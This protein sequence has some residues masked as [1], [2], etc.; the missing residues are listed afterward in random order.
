M[1]KT[2]LFPG[3]FDPFTRGHQYIVEQSLVLFDQIVIGVGVNGRKSG[4]LSTEKRKEIISD[5]FKGDS[6]VRVESYEILTTDFCRE[7][8][9]S[10]IIRG[11]RNGMDLDMEITN[12]TIN[13]TL[14]PDISTLYFTTPVS[15]QHI[16]SS[17]VRELHSFGKSSDFMLPDGISLLDYI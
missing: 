5:I 9:A 8:G 17:A 14:A 1:Q 6:R 11:L 16:S 12:E 4:F 7:V 2:A 3:S 13:R 10:H 15:L